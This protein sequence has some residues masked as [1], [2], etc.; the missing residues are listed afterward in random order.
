MAMIHMNKKKG[1]TM[2]NS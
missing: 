2:D 1:D